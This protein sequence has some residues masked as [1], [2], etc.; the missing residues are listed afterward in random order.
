MTQALT[1]AWDN[2][3]DL[4]AYIAFV[5]WAIG[6]APTVQAYRRSNEYA[7]A[8]PEQRLQRFSDWVEANLYGVPGDITD[9]AEAA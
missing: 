6:H 1:T 3:P 5:E 4:P 9:E 2:H 7:P 8:A